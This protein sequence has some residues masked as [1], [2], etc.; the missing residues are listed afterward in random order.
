MTTPAPVWFRTAI[1]QP[2]TSHYVEVDGCPIHYLLWQ[3]ETSVAAPRGLLFVHG[4]GAHANW[5]RF[6]A[7]FLTRAFRVAAIDFSG[8][9]DSGERTAYT[10]E[11]RV[12]EMRAVLAH[13]DLGPQPF[14]VGH[15]YGGY[16]LMRLGALYGAELGGAVIVDSPVCSPE[17]IVDM[18]PPHAVER[19]RCYD[20]FED[21]LARFR[22]LPGQPCDNDFI[23]EFIG[24][25]SLKEVA[26]GW[27]WK[28]GLGTMTA[29]RL[30]V[31]YN[32]D[33][34][35]MGSRTALI[36]GQHSA[37]VSP[38]TAAYMSAQLG[39]EVPIIEIPE[40]HHHVMLDQ[41]LGFV[42]ALRTLLDLWAR[43]DARP[44]LG[45]GD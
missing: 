18:P 28:F 15:S 41:P 9:G 19:V 11:H 2:V 35:R 10:A 39:P 7:P 20:R 38:E 17:A 14:V 8:M 6:I 22:L 23:V 4:G 13:A 24:R 33:L 29:E 36:Y 5:W 27:T 1:A 45:G 42:S 21:G 30:E 44:A 12:D 34:I 31:L 43:A 26:G 37:L 16:M 3:P 40:A 25:H 32:R